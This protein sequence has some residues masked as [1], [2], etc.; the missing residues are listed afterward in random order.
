MILVISGTNREGSCSAQI[1]AQV[2]EFLKDSSSTPE[3]ELI[4]LVDLPSSVFS[5]KAYREKPAEIKPFIDEVLLCDGMV[6]VVPEYNGSMPGALKY[7]IDL[8]PSPESF[9]DR[10]VAFIGIASGQWAGL[11]AVEHLQQVFGYRNAHIYPR[12]V[13]ISNIHNKLDDYGQITDKDLVERLRTQAQGFID[14]CR[15]FSG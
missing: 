5:P 7:F 6:V 12:R 15:N 10:P 1:A 8:L 11:R 13:F 9:E 14:Y 3:V 4:D 2:A